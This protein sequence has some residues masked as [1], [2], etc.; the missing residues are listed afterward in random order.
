MT[1]TSTP[2]NSRVLREAVTTLVFRAAVL[3][4]RCS[5][6]TARRNRVL[7]GLAPKKQAVHQVGH[8]RSREQF[9]NVNPTVFLAGFHSVV[10]A[11]LRSGLPLPPGACNLFDRQHT[12]VPRQC[13][14]DFFFPRIHDYLCRGLFV[15][16]YYP[17]R[18]NLIR[19]DSGAILR[20]SLRCPHVAHTMFSLDNRSENIMC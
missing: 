11:A 8:V 2:N 1:W 13:K 14:Q 4:R 3:A 12:K 16:R 18:G 10:R 20:L 5:N 6:G 19:V 15:Q 9:S 7:A 17:V